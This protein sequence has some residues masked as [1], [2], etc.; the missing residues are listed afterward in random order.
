MLPITDAEFVEKKQ[1]DDAIDLY[2]K[3]TRQLL[4]VR[5][6]YGNIPANCYE[7]TVIL[8]SNASLARI[9]EG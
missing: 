2:C 8:Y 4:D 9:V 3:I 6:N 5:L 1:L 7:R